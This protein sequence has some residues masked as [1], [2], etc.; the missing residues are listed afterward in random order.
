MHQ[1]RTRRGASSPAHLFGTNHSQTVVRGMAPGEIAFHP[2]GAFRTKERILSGPGLILSGLPLSPDRLLLL[3]YAYGPRRS[4][5]RSQETIAADSRR[6][7]AQEPGRQGQA[8]DAHRVERFGEAHRPQGVRGHGLLLRGQSSR[9]VDSEFCPAHPGRA[10]QPERGHCGGY[11]RGQPAGAA[12]GDHW[13][14][15]E[16]AGRD[17]D[18]PGYQRPGAGAAVQRDPAAASAGIGGL[19]VEFDY[20]R[21]AQA[22]TD[23]QH[24]RPGD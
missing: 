4:Q 7:G 11:P 24:C 19:G 20:P 15:E 22:G 12:S 13:R 18:L 10:R 23:P 6:A 1:P 21:A 5:S 16:A 9:G 14:L 17:P 2:P 8:C 3:N